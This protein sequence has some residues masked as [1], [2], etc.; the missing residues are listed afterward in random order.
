MV[1]VTVPGARGALTRRLAAVRA[2]LGRTVKGAPGRA[3][4]AASAVGGALLAV[5]ALAGL[6]L[7]AFGAWMAWPPAGPIVAG[8]GLIADRLLDERSAP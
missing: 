5:Q 4:A 7:V 6:A 2:R 1:T 3:G 8:A